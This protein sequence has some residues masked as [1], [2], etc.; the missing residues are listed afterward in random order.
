MG[1]GPEL[2]LLEDFGDVALTWHCQHGEQVLVPLQSRTWHQFLSQS[3][4]EHTLRA[5][6]AAK[7]L[8]QD[9]L[10]TLPAPGTAGVNPAQE[11]SPTRAPSTPEPQNP[12]LWAQCAQAA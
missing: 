12:A 1:E 7:P 8:G 2:P 10:W 5:A 6:A 9:V 3:S 4:A 11:S